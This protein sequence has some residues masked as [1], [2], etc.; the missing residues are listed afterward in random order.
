MRIDLSLAGTADPSSGL[1]AA[2]EARETL[3]NGT[4]PGA[5]M[6]GWLD[7]PTRMGDNE[8][9][10]MQVAADT[11]RNAGALVV[12]GIGGSFQ[13]ANAVIDAVVT[14][15]SS[16]LDIHFAG[17]HLDATFHEDLLNSLSSRRYA[18]NIISKSGTTLE[19]SV[20]FDLLWRDLSSRF[21]PD[22]IKKLVF[23]TTDG[24]KG[25]LLEFARS[26]G[27]TTFPVPDDVGGRFSVLSPVGLLPLAAAGVDVKALLEG[28]RSMA[29]VVRD[30]S[31]ATVESNPALAYASFRIAARAASMHIEIMASMSPRLLGITEWWRQL[32]GE[33]EGKGEDG[34]FP[35]CLFYP[36]DLHSL[37][38]WIQEGPAI[39]FETALDVVTDS[40]LVVPGGADSLCGHLGGLPVH[41]INRTIAEGALHAH[42][43]RGIPCG[44][45]ELE[46]ICE[47]ELGALLY[48]MEYAC[49]V[50]AYAQGVNPFDQPG[51]E[52]Y[53]KEARKLLGR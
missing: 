41:T 40:D 53:K 49:A 34:I 28:A 23:V 38:Q 17:H 15:F 36:T 42:S 29:R 45:I 2:L 12:V 50:S 32:F 46:R 14:P 25:R 33:S 11:I 24:G 20:A 51:V 37:G 7:L 13:G 18:V 19:P 39:A 3:E 6:R 21:D 8:L 35:A 27:L 1:S 16:D 26:H 22:E 31:N 30:P 10:A 47:A 5:E 52:A 43:A 4:G 9:A 44:R 48:F